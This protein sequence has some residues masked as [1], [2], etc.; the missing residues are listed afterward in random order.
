MTVY[1]SVYINT[2]K[3]KKFEG[4]DEETI[5]KELKELENMDRHAIMEI[6]KMIE[7]TSDEIG[8]ID[9]PTLVLQGK[10]D[11]ALYQESA[12]FIFDTV[13]TTEKEIIWYPNSGHIITLGQ[14]RE[15][16]YQDTL[17]FLDQLDWQAS[18]EATNSSVQAL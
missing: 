2:L 18:A 4:K 7:H 1:S 3:Y 6:Q 5:A 9:T 11:D 15:Q 16:V 8:E 14:E 10:L 13:D 12:P 17:E